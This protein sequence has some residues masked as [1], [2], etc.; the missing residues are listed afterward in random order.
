MD[1][2]KSN[3]ARASPLN[4]SGTT[5]ALWTPASAKALVTSGPAQIRCYIVDDHRSHFPH[6][7]EAGAVTDGLLQVIELHGASLLPA[8]VWVLR[9]I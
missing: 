5:K 9:L 4:S 2:K 7:P 6:R 8:T 1:A 3:A